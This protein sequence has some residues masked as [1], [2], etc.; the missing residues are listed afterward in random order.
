MGARDQARRSM[1]LG[2]EAGSKVGPPQR[3]QT[4]VQNSDACTARSLG[5][6]GFATPRL[7]ARPRRGARR[8]LVPVALRGRVGFVRLGAGRWDQSR[9]DRQQRLR[10]MHVLGAVGGQ[11]ERGRRGDCAARRAEA[12]RVGR[13]TESSR[14]HGEPVRESSEGYGVELGHRTDSW[15]CG[16]A[17]GCT[18]KHR[19][20]LSGFRLKTRDAWH[21]HKPSRPENSPLKGLILNTGGAP[22]HATAPKKMRGTVLAS[23]S[24]QTRLDTGDEDAT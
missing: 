23:I 18:A 4:A 20:P 21:V 3:S 11:G 17:A 19:W 1:A 9:L 12:G 22:N 8:E 10:W 14:V 2:R 6:Q 5:L 7:D 24:A 16:R 13:E 15:S